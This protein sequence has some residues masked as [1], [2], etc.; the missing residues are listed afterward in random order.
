MSGTAILAI[1][2]E[3]AGANVLGWVDEAGGWKNWATNVIFGYY[4]CMQP[5]IRFRSR[6][7]QVFC[8][9]GIGM[10]LCVFLLLFRNESTT[11]VCWDKVGS[12]AGFRSFRRD[13]TFRL[14]QQ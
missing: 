2:R 7:W 13:F 11:L 9:S 14:L 12:V 10:S 4:V 6:G 1:S 8:P 3:I 5:Q